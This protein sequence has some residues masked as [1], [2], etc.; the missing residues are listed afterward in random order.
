MKP[1]ILVAGGAGYVGAHTCKALSAAGYQPVVFDNLSTGHRGFVRWGDLIEGDIRDLAAVTAAIQEH[2]VVAVLHFAACAYVRESFVDPAKYYENNV[3]GTLSLLNGMRAGGCDKVVFSSSCAVYGQPDTLPIAETAATLPTN[4]YG[5]SKLM[6][7]RILADYAPAYGL[8][9]ISLR[10]FNASGADAGQALGELRDP[11]THLIPRA[12]MAVLGHITDFHVF[13]A[14]FPTPDGTAIRDY[15]HVSDLADAHLSALELL[16]GGHAGGVFNLGTGEGQSV[17][18]VLSMIQEVTGHELPAV[19]VDRRLTCEP[20][21]LVA[22]ATLARRLLA[23]QPCR[24]DL[25]T[26]IRTAWAWHQKAH[27]RNDP[28]WLAA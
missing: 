15:I 5:A 9:S 20:A 22:D 26:I 19:R 27:A 14:D 6:S 4:P 8:R 7:E 28:A 25:R 2:G 24:S 17:R 18:A 16:L 1:A 13:G 11:E 23:F 3:A 10:Y 21:R 12:L